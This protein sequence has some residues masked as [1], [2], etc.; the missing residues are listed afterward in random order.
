M[1]KCTGTA[2]SR[3][4]NDRLN[5]VTAALDHDPKTAKVIT[6]KTSAH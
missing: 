4:W 1:D 5:K 2:N 3:S 6:T